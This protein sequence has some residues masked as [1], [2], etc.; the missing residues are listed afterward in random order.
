VAGWQGGSVASHQI[1]N[2][3]KI[4]NSSSAN[5]QIM[6]LISKSSIIKF[7][8]VIKRRQTISQ[9]LVLKDGG[10]WDGTKLDS[11]AGRR[12]VVGIWLKK[13]LIGTIWKPFPAV[14]FF[15]G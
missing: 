6:S 5:H 4:I 3:I 14:L 2:I 9:L 13:G 10:G 1:I 11:A 15:W 12:I 7:Y 8:K